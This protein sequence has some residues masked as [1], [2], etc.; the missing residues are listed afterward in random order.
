L[1]RN[2]YDVIASGIEIRFLD[3]ANE[4]N[5]SRFFDDVDFRIQDKIIRHLSE[6][7]RFMNLAKRY[8]NE[9]TTISFEFLTK[10]PDKCLEY[11]SKKFDIPFNETRWSD[12]RIKEDIKNS[13]HAPTRVPREK[14]EFRKK[15]DLAVKEITNQLKKISKPVDG[16]QEIAHVGTISANGDKEIGNLLAELMERV[17]KHGTIT[18]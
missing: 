13:E 15:I 2:P 1:L 12:E 16:K 6:Y 3:T 10:T 4:K 5:Q 8:D 7:N 17:G 18:V 11:V 9:I 14:S